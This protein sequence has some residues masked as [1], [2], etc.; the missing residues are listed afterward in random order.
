MR[1]L[2]RLVLAVRVFAVLGALIAVPAAAEEIQLGAAPSNPAQAGFTMFVITER[3]GN[4]GFQPITLRFRAIGKSFTRQRQLRILFRPRTQYATEIDFQFACN[5]TVPQG[6]K[7]YDLPVQVPHFYRWEACSVQ[8]I[9]DGRRLGKVASRL[10]IP[11]SVQDWGQYMSIGV[12][13]PRDAATSNVPWARFPDL[14]SIATIL[15]EGAISEQASVP[16]LSDKLA[17]KFVDDLVYS[18]ARFRVIDED[19]LQTSWIGYSQLDL[20]LAPYPLLQRIEQEQPDRLADLK[21]WVAAGG[22]IW[23]YA[24]PLQAAP[25]PAASLQTAPNA[26]SV[27]AD[28]VGGTARAVRIDRERPEGSRP[29]ANKKHPGWFQSKWHWASGPSV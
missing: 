27:G 28:A 2:H 14:R 19:A 21:R 23:A 8:V 1:R 10:S 24:A 13:V 15:G 20:I 12:M 9:E 11:A 29:T 26:T 5:A 7:T 3:L 16:R 18:W 25:S 4:E 6:V 17:R 22:Q